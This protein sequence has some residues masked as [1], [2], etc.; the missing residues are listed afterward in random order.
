M[1]SL[2]NVFIIKLKQ[3][4]EMYSAFLI[5]IVSGTTF[6]SINRILIFK[7]GK[8]IFPYY[9]FYQVP[10]FHIG[11]KN[12]HVYKDGIKQLMSIKSSFLYLHL[13]ISLCE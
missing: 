2:M 6:D 5:Y 3:K 4:I 11:F 1:K 12:L 8:D 10:I 7:N 9:F 13:N